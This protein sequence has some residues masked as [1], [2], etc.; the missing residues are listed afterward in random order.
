MKRIPEPELMDT[1]E[2]ARA[3]AAADFSAAHQSY[4]TLFHRTFLKRPARA[5]VLDLGCGPADVTVRFAKANPGYT[6]HAVD[7]SAAMLH[8]AREALSLQ[9]GLRKRIQLIAG[10]I[11]GAPIP[12]KNYEVILSNNFLH[13][14]HDPQVLWK[15]V[16]DVS[17]K[18]T[19]VFV[20]DLFR[21]AGRARAKAL[22]RKYSAAEAPILK[23]DFYHSLLAAFT[24]DEIEKQLAAA[25]LDRLRIKVVSDR[26]L[27]VYGKIC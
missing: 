3:Y 19:L 16:R 20:T 24:P 18:G 4:V 6:F 5:A 13:H 17:K 26:H 1:A 9:R 27:I 23:R 21:P 22:V 8:C 14:L 2:Q 25:G 7:G 10:C 11:P 15:C 12:R